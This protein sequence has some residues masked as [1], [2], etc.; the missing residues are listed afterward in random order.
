[1][2][3]SSFDYHAPKTLKSA[4]RLLNEN[5]DAKV[6]AGGHSLIP[7]M[8]LRLVAPQVV[9]DLGKVHGLSRIKISGGVMQ[10][11]ALTT[12]HTI[13]SNARLRR[14]CPVLPETA[15]EIGDAQVRNRGTIGGSVVHADPAADWPAAL[16]TEKV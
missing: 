3:P 8:K 2:I 15:T 1:M 11:G 9:V 7:L 5:E 6:M 13:A 4:L 16:H 12:H 10:I 14:V